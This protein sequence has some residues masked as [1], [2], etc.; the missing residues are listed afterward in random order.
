LR[1]AFRTPEAIQRFFASRS[2]DDEI[3][4]R[5]NTDRITAREITE[6]IA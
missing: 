5:S 3:Q 4:K 1:L 6:S 2:L